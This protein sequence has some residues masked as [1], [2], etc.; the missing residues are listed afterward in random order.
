M[1]YKN[2]IFTPEDN[3]N[4]NIEDIKKTEVNI[5]K[6]NIFEEANCS[7]QYIEI[8][9]VKEN[10]ENYKKAKIIFRSQYILNTYSSEE[11]NNLND[12]V[13][14]E[15]KEITIIINYPHLGEKLETQALNNLIKKFNYKIDFKNT[16][17]SLIIQNCYVDSD[18]PIEPISKDNKL[19]LNKLEISDELYSLSTNISTLFPNLK[20]DELVLKKFKFNSKSQLSTFCKF[21]INV[22][23]I[24]LTLDD[25]FI[26]LI[27]KKDEND[28]EFK[29]LDIYFSYILGT[30]TLDNIHTSINSLTLRDCPLFAI[31]G[32]IFTYEEDKKDNNL[33]KYID[34]DENSLI[35]PS[36]ITKFK[37][38]NGKYD[39]CFDLDSYKL[40]LEENDDDNDYDAIDYFTFIFKLIIEFKRSNEKIKISKDDDGIQEIHRKHFHKLTF[41]NFDFS[42]FEYIT[43]DELTFIE[44]KLWVLNEEE[45]KR[46]KRW[47]DLENDLEEF[48]YENL[49]QV[50][51]LVFDNCSNFFIKWIIN[52]IKG[53]KQDIKRSDNYDFDLLKI[54]KC[55]TEY[56]DLSRILTMKINKLILFD[57]PLIIGDKFPENDKDNHLD[58]IKDNLGTITNLTIKLNSLDCYGKEYNLNTYK[59][60]EILVELIKS[61]K[62]N[63]NITFELCALS[64]IMTFLAYRVYVKDLNFYNDPNEEEDDDYKGVPTIREITNDNNNKEIIREIKDDKDEKVVKK[65]EKNI[66][67]EYTRD[68]NYEKNP[69]FLIKQMFFSSKKMRD[70]LY[71]QSFNLGC[72]KDSVITLKNLTIKKQT[73]NFD[74][75]NYLM[76]K[77]VIEEKKNDNK[78]LK[79]YTN[80]NQLKKID[81]G[82]DG[83]Y[84]DRDYKNFFSEN[85][86]KEVV[87]I[88][89]TFS[90]IKDNIL[91]DMEGETIINLI[92]VNKYEQESIEINKYKNIHFPNYKI[93]VKTLNKILFKNY[94][95]EE[96]GIMFKY[97][98]YKISQQKKESYNE[99]SLDT[100]EKKKTIYD[101][102][103]K[104]LEVF[105]YFKKNIKELTIIINNIK[106]LKDFY[107]IFTLL[108]ILSNNK[109]WV[110]E[111][112]KSNGKDFKMELPDQE[113]IEKVF[114]A[115]FLKE[116]DEYEKEVYSK[117]NYY[118][119]SDEENN[120]LINKKLEANGYKFKLEFNFDNIYN[121]FD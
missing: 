6:S 13:L 25:I 54:K 27:L 110:N 52:F 33:Q 12:D 91:K 19:F 35:N 24:K 114:G 81:F 60:L 93:D 120:M 31:I 23:C 100:I 105:D 89:V 65:E 32:N 53:K 75:Q 5:S 63:G 69:K 116:K 66:Q 119:I 74:N 42:K 118:Y 108:K 34:I 20:V 46:K 41:K 104:F 51:E 64:N 48:K 38:M 95:F 26:D 107:F 72:L 10:N 44:E 73:E 22:E 86:I 49:S 76:K 97:Y 117:I 39:I 115:Y 84:I 88:N 70:Y 77:K 61:P 16:K 30:I 62:F 68:E 96:F 21:I 45:K 85:E 55:A 121:Q 102:F 112:L 71:Y 36:I 83:F 92:G 28:E 111:K 43:N 2:I 58:K 78:D 37:I 4:N 8:F 79:S 56:V 14:N 99:V 40:K 29:D 98:I 15:L 59:T 11:F 82:S 7:G 103:K 109:N 80:N 1:D 87:L 57:S 101:Y 47:E 94:G 67:G 106:E 17:L 18:K 9:T 90:N 50:T 113:K 3:I